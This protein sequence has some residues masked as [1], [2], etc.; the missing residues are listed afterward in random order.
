MNKM[1]K[2]ELKF[3]S[4]Y[5]SHL[6]EF[7]KQTYCA[8][9]MG[10]K[11]SPYSFDLAGKS[12]LEIGAG[13]QGLVLRCV[14][15]MCK[16][17]EPLGYPQW[18][19]DRYK[20]FGVAYE[21]TRVEDMKET[22]WDEVWVVN[23][24][25]HVDDLE[26]TLEKIAASAKVLRIFE[27][28]NIPADD[29]HQHTLTKE[30]LDGSFKIDGRTRLI[31]RRFMY[32]TD[33]YYG[34]YDLL[35]GSSIASQPDP[36]L[37]TKWGG[38]LHRAMIHYIKSKEGDRPLIGVEVGVLAGLSTEIILNILNIKKLYLV[39]PYKVYDTDTY[40][41]EELDT[42]HKVAV[43]RLQPWKD[44]IEWVKMKSLDAAKMFEKKG[45]RF[46]FGYL[47]PSHAYDDVIDDANA[48]W[49]LVIR[50]LG[51]HDYL[52][53]IVE[54]ENYRYIQVMSAIND[55]TSA[56][57][58]PFF[59]SDFEYSDWWIDKKQLDMPVTL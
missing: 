19:W 26:L 52:P 43:A 11:F 13:P 45:I 58:R 51:G 32:R 55:W 39:D 30:I 31:R 10:L 7:D 15:G 29:V 56:H 41:Q 22:G 5:S 49:D 38:N 34:A 6:C 50:Y 21:K 54:P 24:L 14:N 48:W 2:Q 3:W 8:S 40:S 17:I 18:V 4:T 53:D 44:K 12:V 35:E 23:V 47:D 33:A 36:E 42:A 27:W 1:Q 37:H 20:Y 9:K 46:D 59:S 25:Q 28:L 16:V 57:R